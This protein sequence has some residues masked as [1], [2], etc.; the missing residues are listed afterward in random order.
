MTVASTLST[1]RLAGSVSA[2]VARERFGPAIKLSGPDDVPPS[3]ES[4]TPGW[5]AKALCATTPGAAVTHLEVM[6]GDN[7]TSARR[8]M[9]V[10]YNQEGADAGLPT[11]IFTKSSATLASR[12]LLG[13]TDIAEGEAA[14][15]NLIR[16]GLEIRSPRAY[17]AGFDR[18]THRSIVLLEDLT[19]RGWTFPDPQHNKVT[20]HDAEDVVI[21]MAT[22]HAALWESPRLRTD[23]R[24]LKKA[25]EWQRNLNAKVGFERRTMKGFDRA[26]E[27]I[28]ERLFRQR[29]AFYASFMASLALHATAPRTLLH[30][31]LHLGN[32]LRDDN[33][34]M[35][36]YDWQCVATGHWA[37]DYSYALAAALETD[38]RRNWQEPL[39][40]LYLERLQD[41]G[42]AA[43]PSFDDA[44]LAYR[45]QPLHAFAFGL[46]TYGGSRFEPE[47]QPKDYTLAA[48][49]RIA[50]HVD[51][52]E[53]LTANHGG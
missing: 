22:Y 49:G 7:G 41:A 23:L 36:L 51:D 18:R 52:L 4:I 15:Y 20:L 9:R 21:E 25:D 27:V 37:L 6:G 17:Y 28:P 40:R 33:G 34:R 10:S 12:L 47:L 53:S 16:S 38:D 35:G 11:N 2:H 14:F 19:D 1:L 45:Q 26:R 13:V 44:W 31:D 8:A 30:Q 3:A 42:V 39:L 46:F 48:I 29:D 5:L 24:A 32:W 43:P 50:R